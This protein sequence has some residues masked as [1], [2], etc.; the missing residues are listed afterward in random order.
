MSA[1]LTDDTELFREVRAR[2]F[3]SVVGDTLDRCG[4]RHQFLPPRIKPLG[5]YGVVVGRAMPVLEVDVF[6]DRE[7]FGDMFAALDDLRPGEIYL[8]AGGS[9]T[10]AFFGELMATA[11]TARGAVGAVLCG[12]HR[13][14]I[15]LQENGFPVFSYG[16]YGQDQGVR[17]RVLE[18]RVTI[19]VE[20]VRIEPGDLLVCDVDGVV[21]VP[22]RIE[23]EVVPEALAKVSTE[24]AVRA[25]LRKGMPAA[26]AFEKFGV[27]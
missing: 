20:G 7:P 6:D 8:A 3:S 2:L 11:A 9:T 13:D 25:A 1:S 18:Y 5:N 14:T 15:A 10:Y 23:S 12:Y 24:S 27:M 4:Y 19:E 16:G 26:E 22:R 17:G 21:V